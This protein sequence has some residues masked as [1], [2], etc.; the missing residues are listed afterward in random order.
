MRITVVWAAD[1]LNTP[2]SIDLSREVLKQK[3]ANNVRL[4]LAERKARE[5]RWTCLLP[6]RECRAGS[7]LSSSIEVR[8][9]A[10][11]ESLGDLE[12]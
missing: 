11:D 3:E 1:G 7:A 12:D 2:D 10:T 9:E 6:V 4:L 8:G 5:C